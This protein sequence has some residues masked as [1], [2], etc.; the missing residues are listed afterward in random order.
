MQEYTEKAIQAVRNSSLAYCRFLTAND[1]GLTGGHQSGIYIAKPAVPIIF[2]EPGIRGNNKDR[3]A[4][5]RWQDGSETNARFIYYGQGSRNEYRITNF[6]QN[7]PYLRPDYTGALFVLAKCGA[8]DYLGFVLNTEEDIEEFLDAFGMSPAETNRLIRTGNIQEE[9]QEEKEK[10]AIQKYINGLKTDFPFTAEMAEAARDIQ[11]RVYDHEE[12]VHTNPDRK[13]I[14]WVNTEYAIFRAIEQARYGETV[15]HGF[16][17]VDDFVNLANEILNRRKSRAGKSLEHHLAAIFNGNGLK[18]SAQ[19]I[20]EGKNRPDFIFP[21]QEAY[22]QKAFP[23]NKLAVLAAKRTCKDRWRQI[24]T[25]S[26]L[27]RDRPKY[28]F[29]LQ[30]GMSPAQMDEMHD[31]N[32]VLVVPKP[33][34]ATYPADRR[35]RIWTLYKF[36]SYVREIEKP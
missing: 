8:G 24:L 31:K 23:L 18:Y 32:V 17:T 4:R 26:K 36:I 12:F 5:I 35:D 10:L 16:A 30:Q 1:T 25:E 6:G 20:T 34:I 28:L 7:F 27:M 9:D 29:T 33:Y 3:R 15:A 14:N 22:Q 13:I 2:D 11:N 21:S 19:A